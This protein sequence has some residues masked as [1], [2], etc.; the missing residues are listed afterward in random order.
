M[1]ASN[2]GKCSLKSSSTGKGMSASSSCVA[3]TL[4]VG[5]RKMKK[6]TRSIDA[7][8]FRYWRSARTSLVGRPATWSTRTRSRVTLNATRRRSFSGMVSP[9]A[10][11]SAIST[12]R[13]PARSSVTGSSTVAEPSLTCARPLARSVGG[14]SWWSSR[15]VTV[16]SSHASPPAHPSSMRSGIGTWATAA[17]AAVT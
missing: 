12:M 3:F 2:D 15:A 5:V 1:T 13:T 8:P 17:P 4:S 9:L 16:S 10:P 14:P 11:E 6:A 7:S